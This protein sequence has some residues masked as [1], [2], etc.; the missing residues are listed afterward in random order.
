MTACSFALVRTLGGQEGNNM[1]RH[2][3][4]LTDDCRTFQ[5]AEAI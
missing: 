4:F 3:V 5:R 2:A 1:R